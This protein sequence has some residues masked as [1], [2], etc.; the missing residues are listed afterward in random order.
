MPSTEASIFYVVDDT[1]PLVKAYRKIFPRL[2]SD[3]SEAPEGL[4]EHFRYPEDLFLVQTSMWGRYRLGQSLGFY[5]SSGRWDVAQDPGDVIGQVAQ[6]SVQDEQG[7]VIALRDK[8]IPPQYLLMRLPD[9][10]EESFLMF[11]PFV[12]FSDDDTRQDLAGFMV[13]H[14]DPGRYGEIE[15]FE[16]IS[17]G[18]R[19]DG[20]AQF[21]SRINTEA[22]IS[23][24]IS[25]LNQQGSRVRPGNLLL[26]PI[27]DSLLYVRPLFIEATQSD[28]P[29]PVLERVIVGF[30]NSVAMRDN[31]E[32]A[33]QAVLE[34]EGASVPDPVAS[35]DGEPATT[36]TTEPPTTEVPPTTLPPPE[37]SV[38]DLLQRALDAFAEADAALRDGDLA[39][40]EDALQRAETLIRQAE[41]LSE[42]TTTGTTAPSSDA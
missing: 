34:A 4:E 11:R 20:P 40:Y 10:T 19:V 28:T 17:G 33:L 23:R 8:R 9:D 32:E 22:D 3:L 38:S 31:F 42:D 7:N 41:Q 39:G 35:D 21:N 1:D 6:E 14:S 25:L 18:L 5:N 2:F 24:E 29:I 15:V 26:F 27:G 36:P 37:G 13:A 12:P 30:G 16:V